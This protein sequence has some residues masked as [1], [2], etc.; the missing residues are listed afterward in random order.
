LKKYVGRFVK[1][2]ALF[3]WL[4]QS[5]KTEGYKFL[6]AK[7][8]ARQSSYFSYSVSDEAGCYWFSFTRRVDQ[9]IIAFVGVKAKLLAAALNPKSTIPIV[10]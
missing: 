7:N 6:S 9:K 5:I 1:N 8:L 2:R 4:D 3:I 10:G